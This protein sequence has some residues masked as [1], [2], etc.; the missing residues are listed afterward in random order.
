MGVAALPLLLGMKRSLFSVHPFYQFP[1]PIKPSLI[2]DPGRQALI[3]LDRAVE[4]DAHF[5]HIAYVAPY[6]AEATGL[7][8]LV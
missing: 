4:F 5:S 1:D 8:V 3:M 7:P 6:Q 2:R